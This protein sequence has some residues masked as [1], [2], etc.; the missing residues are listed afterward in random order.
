[1]SHSFIKAELLLLISSFAI[2]ICPFNTVA[3]ADENIIAPNYVLRN[4]H[5]QRIKSP[6][7]FEPGTTHTL[8]LTV[9]NSGDDARISLDITNEQTSDD[10]QLDLMPSTSRLLAGAVKADSIYSI[11]TEDKE[12]MLEH[13]KKRTIPITITMPASTIKGQQNY[14]ASLTASPNDNL[15]QAAD[16]SVTLQMNI[17]NPTSKSKRATLHF[18]GFSASDYAGRSGFTIQ[19]SNPCGSTF[20]AKKLT[21]K[22]SGDTANDP[23]VIRSLHSIEVAPYSYFNFFI[24]YTPMS[25][26]HYRLNLSTSNSTDSAQDFQTDVHHIPAGTSSGEFNTQT[27]WETRLLQCLAIIGPFIIIGLLAGQ[28]LL[29]T[30]RTKTQ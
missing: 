3:A 14:L 22:I 12:F 13:N 11:M 30:R 26:G 16:Q 24:P 25:V 17:K 28:R 6:F 1:M 4:E 19:V 18:S 8:M 15:S 21:G 2:L 27:K 9:T 5:G 20:R 10:G 7:S 23:I 29:L